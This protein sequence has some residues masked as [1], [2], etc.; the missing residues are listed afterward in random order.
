MRDQWAEVA[1]SS[2]PHALTSTTATT[3]GLS[4]TQ[5][6]T[7][8][9]IGDTKT[10]PTASGNAQTLTWDPEG[11]LATSSDNTRSTSYVY[12]VDGNRLV[13][14]DPGGATLFLPGQEVRYTSATGATTCTR[15]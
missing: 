8:D 12:D 5:G 13:S 6:Y 14:H 9:E 10:R 1:G 7:Y 11:H 4:V 2:K 15:S 3:D